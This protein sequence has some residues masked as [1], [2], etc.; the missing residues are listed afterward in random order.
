[1]VTRLMRWVRSPSD[2]KSLP[3]LYQWLA[4][5]KCCDDAIDV[6]RFRAWRALTYDNRAELSPE[7]ASQLFSSPLRASVSRIETFATC[8]FKHFARYGLRLE[9]R[10]DAEVT[11]LDLGNVYHGILEN[12]VKEMVLS[13]QTWGANPKHVTEAS[14]SNFAQQ[15]GESLRGE[16]MLSSARNQYLL[17]HVE[18]TLGQ[19]IDAQEAAAKRGRFSPLRAEL[20]FGS[21]QPNS[22]P[23]YQMKTPRK[24]VLQLNGKIDRVDVIQDQAAFAVIDYKLSGSSLSLDRVYHGLSLQ[25]LTYLL[26]LQANGDKLAGK[27][28]TPAAA[29]YVKLLRQLDE[30]KHPDEA[31]PPEDEKFDLQIKPRGLIHR[32]FLSAIDENLGP[33]QRSDVVQAAIKQDGELGFKKS[34]DTAEADEFAALLRHV[35]K[36]IGELGDQIISGRID[37]SPYR[38]G[39]VTPCPY[40]EYRPVCRF[41]V[42]TNRYHHLTVLGREAVLEKLTSG[43]DQ[44]GCDGQ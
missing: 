34:T 5:Y 35:E 19:V 15:I 44:G 6:M 10:D 8:P 41:D 25:L 9:Q 29:F 40:C 23:A 24:N 20:E 13:H 21:Q 22:L 31:M 2:A 30:V 7:I 26:V 36:R 39:L 4:T 17:Q 43:E 1:L 38:M 14:I 33:G 32:N 18:K 42:L 16:L 3:A 37:V 11:A 28:L 12:L 27:N